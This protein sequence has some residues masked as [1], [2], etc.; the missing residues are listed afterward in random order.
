MAPPLTLTFVG[1]DAEL[2]GRRDA[3]RG[4]RLVDLDQVEVGGLTPSLAQAVPDRVGRLATAA[5]SPGRRRRR[6]RRS[7]PARSGPSSSALALLMTTTAAAP[8][9]ICDADPAV[10][11]P[12][13]LNAGRSRPRRLDG[14][15]GA[16][17]LVVA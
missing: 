14:G 7:R 9:E 1:V 15:V 12:S 4:E 11:V 2:L 13:L 8:S 16:D 5:S 6:A 10:M 3:D 17:A